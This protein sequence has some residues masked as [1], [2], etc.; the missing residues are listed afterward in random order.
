MHFPCQVQQ[1]RKRPSTR[2]TR[3]QL[4]VVVIE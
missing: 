1:P 2:R 4:E 3:G